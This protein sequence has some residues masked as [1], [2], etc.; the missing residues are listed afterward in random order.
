MSNFFINPGFLIAGI[1]AISAPIIIHLLNRRRFKKID[2]A[3]MDF[4]LEAQRL[5]RRRVRLE[6]IILLF[7]RCLA[8]ILIGL[9]ISRPSLNVNMV[10]AFNT[11][12]TERIIILDDSLSMGSGLKGEKPIE[13]L[14]LSLIK[15]FESL[16]NNNDQD[17]IT[18]VKTTE[19]ARF[20]PNAQALNE[21]SVSE[22][23][24]SFKEIEASD[25]QGDLISALNQVNRSFESKESNFEKVVYL[26]SDLRKTDWQDSGTAN[27][28]ESVTDLIQ[29][30]SQKAS[31]FYIVDLGDGDEG[32]VLIESVGPVDKIIVNGIPSDFEVIV[33]NYGDKSINDI[34]VNFS[35]QGSLPLK[36]VISNIEAGES[37][38]VQF[39]YTFNEIERDKTY[40]PIEV[41]INSDSSTGSD[42]LNDDNKY[43]F[44]API[45]SGIRT[46]VVDGD[47]S[48]I[49][50]RG[51]SFYLAN[52][53]APTGP[54]PSGVEVTIL[55]D[56]DFVSANL[57]QFDVIFIA[58]LYRINEEIV[59]RLESW[60]SQGGGLVFL[61]GDQID[62]DVY[63]DLLY[64]NGS[65]I[66]PLKL[67]KVG[68]DDKEEKWVNF[69]KQKENHPLFRFF[70]G[71]NNQLLDAV[72]VFRWWD[73]EFNAELDDLNSTVL[74]ASY[75]PDENAAAIVEKK[76]GLGK[77]LAMTTPLDND[78]S[79]FP[80]NGASFLITSQ[81]LVRYMSPNLVSDGL[82]S[83]SE[84]IAHK[85]DVREFRQ[86]AKMII[87]ITSDAFQVDALP[88]SKSQSEFDWLINF[89]NTG[90]Q[91]F[92]EIQ[93]AR[94]DGSG[95][96]SVLFAANT[97]PNES[98]LE[99][100]NLND[101][102]SVFSSDNVIFLNSSQPILENQSSVSKSELWKLVLVVLSVLLMIELFYGW[103]I[104]A[105]R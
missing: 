60:V 103:W 69:K 77:V 104:G 14:S 1:L 67:L 48:G 56:T 26:L 42:S 13:K 85:L 71:D 4:L 8:M 82:I 30:I 32:N 3:A 88:M 58:N 86:Q 37:E 40:V 51:E 57:S 18:V 38:V 25:K 92:Y 45:T 81:E 39:T 70:E 22:L 66:L 78:W 6:E 12:Q 96:Y 98:K 95:D 36:K 101:I 65:G 55:D 52:A 44:P 63:N 16:A 10:G 83:V 79:N 99:R 23:L 90:Y 59:S 54:A 27:S 80:E 29:K 62:E 43:F 35:A 31:G 87:P 41:T 93:K 75:A 102:K 105:R 97:D 47:P 73:T 91:G 34:E 33:R 64:K 61:L 11:G 94:A 7:L 15:G 24:N 28:N 84:P 17:L 72:K 9:F 50:G 46:L 21:D 68:G 100:I 20:S 5:N 53:L 19:P 89:E 74:L 76:I 49:S 2:W